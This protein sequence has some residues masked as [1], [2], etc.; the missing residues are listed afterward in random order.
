M[1]GVIVNGFFNDFVFFDFVG[2]NF[3]FVVGVVQDVVNQLVEFIIVY[4]FLIVLFDEFIGEIL[5]YVF[6]LVIDMI[7]ENVIFGEQNWIKVIMVMIMDSFFGI[8]IG[9]FKVEDVSVL[10][11]FY[12]MKF[13]IDFFFFLVFLWC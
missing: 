5:N 8:S 4:V 3:G 9:C 6:V 11:G 10:I 7:I 12:V 1:Q 13:M 2:V